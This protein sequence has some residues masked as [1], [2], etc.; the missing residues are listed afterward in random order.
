MSDVAP[1]DRE[2]RTGLGTAPARASP[3]LAAYF[4][5]ADELRRFLTARTGSQP[6][7]WKR[8]TT[9]EVGTNR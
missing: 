1:E 4:A 2:K 7:P 3:V 6:A 8:S 5:R 9:S